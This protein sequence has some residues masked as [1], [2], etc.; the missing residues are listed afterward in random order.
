MNKVVSP[1]F[2]SNIHN[3]HESP[4]T[5]ME[6]HLGMLRHFHLHYAILMKVCLGHGTT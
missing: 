3:T 2:D 5:K 1:N 4:T 6:I